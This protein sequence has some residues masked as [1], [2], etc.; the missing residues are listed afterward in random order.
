[1]TNLSTDL[2]NSTALTS[3]S[4]P[5]ESGVEPTA[6]PENQRLLQQIVTQ[7]LTEQPLSL[8]GLTSDAG[9]ATLAVLKEKDPSIR[10]ALLQEKLYK[11]VEQFMALGLIQPSLERGVKH[12]PIETLVDIFR[13]TVVV[14][15][16]ENGKKM[17]AALDQAQN[18]SVK[19]VATALFLGFAHTTIPAIFL[20]ALAVKIFLLYSAG[21]ASEAA[22]EKA[23]E[24][25]AKLMVSTIP[26]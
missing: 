13:R 6:A 22:A 15:N 9:A 23:S 5:K 11:A 4:T 7:L 18:F 12:I 26:S 21:M 10:S 24:F 19:F 3:V 1:M 14:A 20:N 25:S 16:A 2:K 17:A 8:S